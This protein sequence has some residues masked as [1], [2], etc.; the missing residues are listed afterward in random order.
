VRHGGKLP[1]IG[2]VTFLAALLVAV[3][4]YAIDRDRS[5]GPLR[6]GTATLAQARAQYGAPPHVARGSDPSECAAK[7]PSVGLDLSFLSFG[8]D[9][10]ASGTLVYAVV[11]AHVWRTDRGLRVGDTTTRLRSLYP[12]ARPRAGG[13]WLVTRRACKEVGGQPF[14]GLRARIG[15]GRVSAFVVSANVCE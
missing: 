6:V 9:A 8:G 3:A 15:R 12:R 7:W 13:W 14:A 10:C 11:S 1:T 2:P 4:P 5:V